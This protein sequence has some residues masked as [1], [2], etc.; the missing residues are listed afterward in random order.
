MASACAIAKLI[1][2]VESVWI[3]ILL[4]VTSVIIACVT[5]SAIRLVLWCRP[6]NNFRISAMA[7]YTQKWWTMIARIIGRKVTERQRGPEIVVVAIITFTL[8]DEMRYIFACGCNI[9]MAT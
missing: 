7:R 3:F 9:V 1:H 2:A 8:G 5:G 6:G 4:M